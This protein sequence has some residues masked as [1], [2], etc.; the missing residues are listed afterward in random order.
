MNCRYLLVLLVAFFS[1]QD[2]DAPRPPV[3]A[4]APSPV[5]PPP[6]PGPPSPVSSSPLPSPETTSTTTVPPPALP[7]SATSAASKRAAPPEP[8]ASDPT[9]PLIGPIDIDT[10]TDEF[11]ADADAASAKYARRRIQFNVG[12][13][14]GVEFSSRT[15]R[16]SSMGVSHPMTN[17]KNKIMLSVD[18]DRNIKSGTLVLVE[19]DFQGIKYNDPQ[20]ANCKVTEVN[21]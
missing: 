7:H 6:P 8:I 9:L 14:A 2:C 10:F 20:L 3:A 19:G 15:G 5:S 17:F 13:V 4:N 21:P 12:E 1:A 16:I 11:I 18:Y